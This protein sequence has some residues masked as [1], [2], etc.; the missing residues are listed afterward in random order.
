MERLPVDAGSGSGP[1]S[2]VDS[3]QCQVIGNDSFNFTNDVHG[4]HRI[5][6]E[7]LKVSEIFEV[8]LNVNSNW[9]SLICVD[10]F[11]ELS[12]SVWWKR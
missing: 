12:S 11:P 4:E 10:D 5:C 8:T 1:C 3:N 7:L 2:G 6:I 9:H